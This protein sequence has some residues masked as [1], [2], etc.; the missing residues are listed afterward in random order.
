MFLGLLLSLNTMKQISDYAPSGTKFI[1]PTILLVKA[2]LVHESNI[3]CN[4]LTDNKFNEFDTILVYPFQTS[5]SKLNNQA[6]F[7]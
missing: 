7:P 4:A 6:R 3:E 5:Y 2:A 1:S